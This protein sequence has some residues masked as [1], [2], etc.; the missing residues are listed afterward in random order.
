MVYDVFMIVVANTDHLMVQVQSSQSNIF[1]DTPKN[2]Q[3]LCKSHGCPSW[4][5]VRGFKFPIFPWPRHVRHVRYFMT[6]SLGP[7]STI[8]SGVL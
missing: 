7:M 8:M 2:A 4:N 1:G 6:Y 3:V 5:Q